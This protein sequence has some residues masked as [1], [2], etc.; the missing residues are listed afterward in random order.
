MLAAAAIERP[1][2]MLTQCAPHCRVY[3]T[4]CRYERADAA[5]MRYAMRSDE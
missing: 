2:I 5:A 4:L 3:A 1:L